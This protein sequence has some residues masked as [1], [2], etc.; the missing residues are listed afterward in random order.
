MVHM[1]IP[2]YDL[3]LLPGMDYPLTIKHIAQDELQR[4]VDSG[5]QFV[6]LP[7]KAKIDHAPTADDFYKIGVIMEAI[8]IKSTKHGLQLMVH[9]TS[10]A[11]VTNLT[12]DHNS[13]IG[14]VMVIYDDVDMDHTSNNEM[15]EYIKNLADEASHIINNGDEIMKLIRE[16]EDLNQMMGFMIQGMQVKVSEKYRLMET[17]S[18][19]KRALQFIDYLKRFQET[20]KIQKEMSEHFN[21][22][23]NKNYREQA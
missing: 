23:A 11:Q 1:I 3:L 19:K 21:E 5:E 18:L 7:I 8:D 16:F 2:I 20:L 4:L 15:I 13:P 12:F 14:E 6:A 17:Q 22:K 10:F 9:I